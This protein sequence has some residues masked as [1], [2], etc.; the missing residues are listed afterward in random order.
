M[1]LLKNR[2]SLFLEYFL[3]QLC[4][5]PPFLLPFLLPFF[6]FPSSPSLLA[7]SPTSWRIFMTESG[8]KNFPHHRTGGMDVQLSPALS[9]SVR[10]FASRRRPF[11]SRLRRM[12]LLSGI[13]SSF[14][15]FSLPHNGWIRLSLYHRCCS[16]SNMSGCGDKH[17]SCELWRDRELFPM[18]WQ[19]KIEKSK[20]ICAAQ[21]TMH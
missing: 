17:T 20:L 2:L 12:H 11:I 7:S 8:D 4:S 9:F 15:S 13:I 1:K 10:V 6:A 18:H 3:L 14:C 19:I 21:T 5:F 16:A